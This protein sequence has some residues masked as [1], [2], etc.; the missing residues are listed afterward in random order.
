MEMKNVEEIGREHVDQLNR[1]L[2]DE[3]GK[4]GLFVTRN[5]LKKAVF[6]RTIDLWSGQRKAL[7]AL[8]DDDI[9]QM[10]ELF[11]SRQRDPI[12]VVVKKYS[13]FRAKCP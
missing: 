9:G 1:Y 8:T 5:P 7:I 3:L 10:V 4:F 13:E 11:E 6:R 2:T 12:D